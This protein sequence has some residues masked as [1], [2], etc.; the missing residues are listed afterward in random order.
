[1]ISL[2]ALQRVRG[3]GNSTGRSD[4]AG[5]VGE[6]EFEAQ[7]SWPLP[8]ES[9]TGVTRRSVFRLEGREVAVAAEGSTLAG[10]ALGVQFTQVQVCF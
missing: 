2:M 4:R 9:S 10:A 1:M 5:S 6:V 7:T 8:L 3:G